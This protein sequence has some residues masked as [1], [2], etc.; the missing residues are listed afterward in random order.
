MVMCYP[1]VERWGPLVTTAT[2][3]ASQADHDAWRASATYGPDDNRQVADDQVANLFADVVGTPL[4]LDSSAQS[5]MLIGDGQIASHSSGVFWYD[6][7]SC[8]VSRGADQHMHGG[9]SPCGSGCS[10]LYGQCLGN[11]DGAVLAGA[12]PGRA[13][14]AGRGGQGAALRRG[15]VRGA[16]GGCW[17]MVKQFKQQ[18]HGNRLPSLPVERLVLA[19][20]EALAVRAAASRFG[21]RT[22]CRRACARPRGRMRDPGCNRSTSPRPSCAGKRRRPRT[23][24][25]AA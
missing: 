4:R 17:H 21:A 24:K 13:R 22:G 6:H 11:A 19:V 5:L 3:I 14:V 1:D 20:P 2:R 7:W 16:G 15:R 18:E 10:T 25:Q 12:G 8:S 9:S 23:R